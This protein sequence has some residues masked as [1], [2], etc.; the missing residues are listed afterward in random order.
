MI[1][2]DNSNPVQQTSLGFGF[3]KGQVIDGDSVPQSDVLVLI[4]GTNYNANTLGDGSYLFLCVPPGTYSIQFSKADADTTI[5]AVSVACEETTFV[6]IRLGSGVIAPKYG[7]GGFIGYD[8]KN[9]RIIMLEAGELLTSP[10]MWTIASLAESLRMQFVLAEDFQ[11]WPETK[12]FE[13]QVKIFH[14]SAL[15]YDQFAAKGQVS[16]GY[17]KL[18]GLDT[19][20]ICM[21]QDTIGRFG[22]ISPYNLVETDVLVFLGSISYTKVISNNPL[23]PY[24]QTDSGNIYINNSNFVSDSLDFDLYLINDSLHDTCYWRNFHPD[25]GDSII[26]ADNPFYLGDK[27]DRSPLVTVLS[28]SEAISC[29]G[30]LPGTYTVAVRFYK[31]LNFG[32]AVFPSLIIEL[33]WPLAGRLN[34]LYAIPMPSSFKEGDFWIAGKIL[35]PERAVDTTGAMV[36]SQ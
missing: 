32:P 21:P 7:M 17:Y 6:N 9:S 23:Q 13:S 15:C 20:I 1:A 2:C 8:E 19:F 22:I 30:I 36:I 18:T 11:F 29:D 31:K 35:A 27:F 16:T 24:L 14:N 4:K 3:I 5:G 12:V 28:N 33:G 34:S 26:R 10:G 25:W